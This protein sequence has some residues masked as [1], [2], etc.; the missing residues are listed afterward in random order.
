MRK[1]LF[2]SIVM[3]SLLLFSQSAI[4]GLIAS[5][6]ACLECHEDVVPAE[7]FAASV[8]GANGC[9]ACHIEL[10][11]LDAHME[12]ELMPEPVKCVRCHKNE[13]QEHYSSV[14]S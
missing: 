1:A 13:T 5:P 9:V 12:G 3:L 10:V 14:H 7:D 8:H 4:A 6:E 2:Y 11:D